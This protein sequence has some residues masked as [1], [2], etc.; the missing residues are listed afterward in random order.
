M[1]GMKIVHAIVGMTRTAGTTVFVR[2][3][4]REQ[5]TQGHDVRIA[6]HTRSEVDA[7]SMPIVKIQSLDDLGYCPDIVHIH[8][9]WSMFLVQ[10]M[11]WCVRKGIPFVVSPH[12]GLMPRVMNKGWL[13]KRLFYSLFVKPLLKKAKAIHCTGEGEVAAV[14][15]LGILVKTFIAP[16]GCR[17]PKMDEETAKDNGEQRNVLFLGRLGE[18][19]GLVLLLDAWKG[20]AWKGQVEPSPSAASWKLVIAGPSWH[21]YGEGLK[22]KVEVEK[23]G[24]VEFT[25]SADETMKDRLYRAADIFVLPSPTENFSMVVL[26]ALAYGVPVICTKGTPWRVI[27]LPPTPPSTS[28]SPAGWWI[29]SNSVEAIRVALEAAMKLTDEER[30]VMG[31]RGREVAQGYSWEHVCRVVMEF[32]AA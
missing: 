20:I 3:L 7:E 24:G 29:E 2:E 17:L 16:L 23:I 8:A 22:N 13:K 11:R 1:H 10:A 14:K 32:Y 27:S 28:P 30:Q 21:G 12:G 26:D 18:E 15:L 5:L 9:I 19:K 25:G 4:A 6:Y 31:A